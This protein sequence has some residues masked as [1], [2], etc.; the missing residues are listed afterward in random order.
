MI[1]VRNLSGGYGDEDILHHISHSFQDGKLSII[2]GKNGS[3]KSTLLK[4]MT[5]SLDSEGEV[6][7]DGL[8]SENL[9]PVEQAS[10]TALVLQNR[11]VPEISVLRLVLHG[12]FHLLSWPRRY[13][14]VDFEKADE[15]LRE[16]GIEELKD[17]DASELS[18]GQRQK[19]YLAQALC[20]DT[21][22]ILL[23]EPASFLDPASQ[24]EMMEKAK[25]LADNGKCVIM[26]SHDLPMAVSYADE[27]VLMDEGKI[28]F[29]GTPE[30]LL[31]SKMVE[32]IFKVSLKLEKDEIDGR[33]SCLIFPCQ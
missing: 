10:H 17:R 31:E 13:R 16:M 26:I 23:D 19:A 28:V 25:E 27:I 5:G 18:G 20:Q 29:S 15:A 8:S 9:S 32:E 12:R 11:S 7:I 3:G 21:R 2:I 14:K 22:N 4:A 33:K 1:E 30:Q 6:L 24:F